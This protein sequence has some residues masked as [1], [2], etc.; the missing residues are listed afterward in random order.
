MLA[1]HSFQ[2]NTPSR[3]MCTHRDSLTIPP[4][5]PFIMIAPC[6][7]SLKAGGGAAP[8]RCVSIYPACHVIYKLSQGRRSG[9]SVPWWQHLFCRQ[10]TLLP[11]RQ[12]KNCWAEEQQQVP[13]QDSQH[14]G[15]V[16]PWGRHIL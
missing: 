13:Q 16:L 11:R 4:Q 14:A 15:A 6:S 1:P 12:A 9:G 3:C 7:P 8:S 2:C 10:L 5:L